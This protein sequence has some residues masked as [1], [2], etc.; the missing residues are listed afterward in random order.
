MGDKSPK[1]T[2]KKAGQNKTRSTA[3]KQKKKDVQD[4]KHVVVPKK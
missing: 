1:S 2:A 3:E 4:A